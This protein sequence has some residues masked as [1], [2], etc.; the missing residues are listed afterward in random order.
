MDAQR[1]TTDINKMENGSNALKFHDQ[2]DEES[3]RCEHLKSELDLLEKRLQESNTDDTIVFI[4]LKQG[5]NTVE[6][7]KK[8]V[9]EIDSTGVATLLDCPSDS[10]MENCLKSLESLAQLPGPS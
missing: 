2:T 3:I 4:L 6:E 10:G 7:A 5:N 1:H 9:S 8:V